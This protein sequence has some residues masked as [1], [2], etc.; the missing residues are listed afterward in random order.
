MAIQ[1]LVPLSGS[2]QP[3]VA[4]QS[5]CSRAAHFQVP[6]PAMASTETNYYISRFFFSFSVHYKIEKEQDAI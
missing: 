4:S 6:L 3:E 1:L 2:P 5:C